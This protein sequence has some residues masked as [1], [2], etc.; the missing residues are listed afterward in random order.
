MFNLFI[1]LLMLVVTI[2]SADAASYQSLST[3]L[4]LNQYNQQLAKKSDVDTTDAISSLAHYY[5][6]NLADNGFLVNSYHM[7]AMAL[8]CANKMQQCHYVL[9]T[10]QQA[11]AAQSYF[12]THHLQLKYAV[13]TPEAYT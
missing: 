6:R 8:F 12:I 9:F 3:A 4:N 2:F 13:F 7:S 11:I 5:R 10:H 1:R